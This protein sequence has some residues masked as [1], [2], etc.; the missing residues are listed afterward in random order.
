[1]VKRK[2]MLALVPDV[3]K[4]LR[5]QADERGISIQELL[6]AV[7]VPEWLNGSPILAE[8][9]VVLPKPGKIGNRWP[10]N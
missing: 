4:T 2:F 1:M 9:A 5:D 8:P 6:R 7:V 3:Y 10:K